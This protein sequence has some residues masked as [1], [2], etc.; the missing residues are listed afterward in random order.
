MLILG[1]LLI[2]LGAL[3]V[4]VVVSDASGSVE[5]LGNEITAITIFLAG[6]CAGLAILW[7]F[8]ILKYGTKRSLQRRRDSKQ[9]TEL[10]DKLDRVEAERRE[11][12]EH[13][14]D[15]GREP[16]GGDTSTS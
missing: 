8:G 9:L 13:G 2:A 7:G 14:G 3:V 16:G 5:L 11:R 10:S 12:R 4:I 15:A 6:V 1:L